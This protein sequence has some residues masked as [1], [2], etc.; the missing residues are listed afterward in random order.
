MQPEKVVDIVTHMSDDIIEAMTEKILGGQP[1]TYAFSKALSE[2][3]VERCGLPVGIARPSIGKQNFYIVKQS[4]NEP[5]TTFGE[6]YFEDIVVYNYQL[7]LTIVCTYNLKD[8]CI[9]VV[10]SWEEPHP[11]WVENMNGPTGLMIGAGKGVIRTVLCN[12]DYL[13]NV[14][15]CDMAINGIIALAWKVGREQPEKPIHMNITSGSENPITWGYAVD[16]GKKYAIMYP[17]TGRYN[18]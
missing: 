14:I 5:F 15:P 13:L 9:S 7:W 2:D 3:L 17:F 1:N 16:T 8:F 4:L 10:A 18:E 12:Y 11:G 6:Q